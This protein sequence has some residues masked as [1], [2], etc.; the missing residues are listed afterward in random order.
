MC[1]LH[2]AYPSL[3][4]RFPLYGMSTVKRGLSKA[5]SIG[6]VITLL[7]SS[8]PAAPL[9]LRDA[10]QV[11]HAKL[12]LLSS[13]TIAALGQTTQPAG[14][15]NPS[16]A[17]QES[18]EE[19]DFRVTHIQVSPEEV[20]VHSGQPA[21]FA[22]IAFDKNGVPV[23]GVHF[24]WQLLGN[25]PEAT[26]TI[27][28]DGEFNSRQ[29]GRYRIAVRGAG[30]VAHATVN[31][32]GEPPEEPHPDRVVERREVQSRRRGPSA[33]ADRSAAARPGRKR[34]VP[35]KSSEAALAHAPG[36]LTSAMMRRFLDTAVWNDEN[37]WS[38][39]DP[40]NRRGP[41][42]NAPD[43]LGGSSSG[44]YQIVVP[45]VSLPGRGLPLD[46]K[47]VYNSRVWNKA[48]SE[49]TFDIDHDD[50]APGWS[51]GFS[52]VV[53]IGS[54]GDMIVEADGTRHPFKGMKT[55]YSGSTT[56]TNYDL[57]TTDGSFIRYQSQHILYQNGDKFFQVKAY[58]PDGSYIVYNGYKDMY[59]GNND[60]AQNAYPYQIT[61]RYGNQI[62]LRNALY[63]HHSK[64]TSITDT[65]GR[66]ILFNY[67][68]A[69]D[70]LLTSITCAGLKDAAGNTT[71]RTLLRLHYRTLNLSQY[72]SYGFDPNVLSPHVR[73]A[74]V[75]VPDAIYYPGLNTGYWF[76]E[77]D[78]YSSYG[79]IAKV[80]EHRD[81]GFSTST[82]SP[83]NE[84]GTV[85]PGRVTQRRVYDYPL[86][87]PANPLTDAPTYTKMTM[88]WANMDTGAAETNFLI[89]NNASPRR[90]KITRP[91]G[92]YSVQLSHNF[93]AL[94]DS[95]PNKLMDG[96]VY[97]QDVYDAGGTL[98][99]R[100]EWEWEMGDH[101]TPRVAREKVTD[102]RNQ[103]TKT[104]YSYG[105]YNQASEIREFGYG[106][107]PIRVTRLQYDNY[108]TEDPQPGQSW[109]Q[110]LAI[111]KLSEV[112][113]GDG[114]TRL[115][116]TEFYHEIYYNGLGPV[117]I[118]D[119]T[120]VVRYGNVSSSAFSDPLVE[121]REYDR[122]GNTTKVSVICSGDVVCEQ[123]Q[124]NFTPDVQYAYATSKIQ[125]APG[126]NTP[127]QVS[128]ST[129]FDFNT[130]L[131]LESTG[132]NSRL[133]RNTYYTDTWRLREITHPSDARTNYV[134]NDADMWIREVVST[135]PPPGGS[136]ADENVQYF[137]GLGQIRRED[138]R[139]AGNVWDIVERRYDALGRLWQQ[140]RP[141]RIGEAPL[142]DE[143]FYDA[144]GRT[145]K[146]KD[147]DGSTS[148]AF[149]NEASPYPPAAT[150]S[151]P[152]QTARVRDAW[153]RERWSRLDGLGRLAEV[154][155]PNPS[156]GG[157][158]GEAGGLLTTYTYDALNNLTQLGQGE[159]VRSFRFDALGRITRQKLP[160]LS[161]AID[162]AG[163]YVGVGG[164]GAQWSDATTYDE[165]S[166]ILTRT[167]SRGVVTSF[168]Y[169]DDANQP[170]PFNRLRRV[171]YTRPPNSV[172]APA[173]D[174]TYE[175]MTTGDR[176]RLRTV[177]AEGISTETYDYDTAGRL[178]YREL[179]LDARPNHPFVTN[180]SYDEVDRPKDLTYPSQYGVPG[181]PR[182]VAHRTYDDASRVSKL[183]VDAA[184]YASDITYDA[185][186]QIKSLAVGATGQ[187]QLT[188]TYEYDPTTNLLAGQKV[189]RGAATLLDLS[190]GYLRAGTTAGRTGQ[191]TGVV[192]NRDHR[193]DRDFEYDP[194]G[195]LKRA[196]AGGASGSWAQRY[197]Y[198][199]YGNRFVVLSRKT[200]YFV[201]NLYRITL[202]RE[203]DSGGLQAWD[204][205]MRQGYGQGQAQFLEAA[206]TTVSGFLDSPEYA[207]RQK[208]DREYVRD[209][210]RV[211]LEREPDQGGWDAWT[212]ACA[213]SGRSAIRPGFA[214]SIEF[215]NKVT[216]MYPGAPTESARTNVALAANGASATASS[217]Y[218]SGYAAGNAIN[219]D[220][221]G[222]NWGSSGGWHDGTGF[223]FPDWL[224]INFSGSKTINEIDVFS[225]QDNY[226]AP[227]EPTE[228]MTFSLYGMTGF[229]VQ[230]WDGSAWATVPGGN[231]SGNSNVWRKFAFSPV[232]TDKIRVLTKASDGWSRL[233][234]VEAYE[235]STGSIN[236]TPVPSDGW[237]YLP[238][239]GATNRINL[240][241]YEYDAAGN[242]TRSQTPYGW[243][244]YEYDAANRL[245]QVKTDLGAVLASY[246]YGSDNKRLISAEADARTYFA[247]DGSVLLAEYVETGSQAVPIWAKNYVYLEGRLLAT[248]ELAGANEAVS[249]HHPDRLGTK[250]I[251][252]AAGGS[253][254]EQATLPFGTEL[255]SEASGFTNTR[256]RFTSYDR[257]ATTGLDYA[258]NRYYDPLQGRFTQVDPLRMGAVDFQDPQTLNLYA[259]CGNDPV[260]RT[261]SRGLFPFGSIFGSIG[262]FFGGLGGL[263]FGGG[264]IIAFNGVPIY[265]FGGARPGWQLPF[266]QQNPK[267]A[268]LPTPTP[269]QS[270][271]TQPSDAGDKVQSVIIGAGKSII[272]TVPDMMNILIAANACE[273]PTPSCLRDYIDRAPRLHY[274]NGYE[275]GGAIAADVAT[276]IL[277]FS[278]VVK[279]ARA[280]R[281]ASGVRD[282]QMVRQSLNV[283]AGRTIAMASYDVQG[284]TGQLVA[285]SGEAL[286]VGTVALPDRLI[287]GTITTGNNARQAEAELKI[288]EHLARRLPFGARGRITLTIERA[289]CYSCENVIN[290]FRQLFPGVKLEVNYPK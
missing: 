207:S 111:P 99:G 39:D 226:S 1:M 277:A 278:S 19:R 142:W 166:N 66:T 119:I 255:L 4:R 223:T 68:N 256:R 62:G 182:K 224:Q 275:K 179:K 147:Y 209:L 183:D 237:G 225:V 196:S 122:Y 154:V 235:A 242:L 218:N 54:E 112:Y 120:K 79:M 201:A 141:Y 245:V 132:V 221:K 271:G 139:G 91:D 49:V 284:M 94:P 130:G 270:T 229:E 28:Q 84:Q 176:S 233:T 101:S 35:V 164:A 21:Y 194:L 267:P 53:S 260:N 173:A 93:S 274:K 204:N 37:S 250:L 148:E 168:R 70:S 219:G 36:A 165:R 195:R 216:G 202:N 191:L 234:E 31:V 42:T 287:F 153:G 83:L 251:T 241:G 96:Y 61:D 211:Y 105:P 266:L 102:S 156:G 47:L 240:P 175:Y 44:N 69:N 199:R 136:I 135:G 269:T 248:Q 100:T 151:V 236:A 283:G 59:T 10:A 41:G 186:S 177:R 43:D 64:I 162:D 137:N 247:Y 290:Q 81:M 106:A 95:D 200:E 230:Y 280:V 261:D 227:S 27:T 262:R 98:L 40:R 57:Y 185:S 76:G 87:P 117:D 129:G 38:A 86:T 149:Y 150:Q 55:V 215:A 244:R 257:S 152:G 197:L 134:Y 5:V 82:A 232:T 272:N 51:L 85:T 65:I 26:P 34:T 67:D 276:L 181:Q 25:G 60:E 249:Y 146:F 159:Q 29:P 116:R 206:K 138:A 189:I 252:S 45:I 155:E 145:I 107:T 289:P 113:E 279:G 254:S 217:E 114:T 80:E 32:S 77:P 281:L 12:I 220:R 228:T 178:N 2:P 16:R 75:Q 213:T 170:D 97:E 265:Q 208:T 128:S 17:T 172:I 192:D 285:V 63:S 88:S 24:E 72:P 273:S 210:Y 33:A 259:Y 171:S 23:G 231:V 22:A 263:L 14:Q 126:T 163:N 174:V 214:N 8:T 238:V 90:N 264:T 109:G 123:T 78:S 121:K 7:S 143:T 52:R 20:N 110:I 288:L 187:N 193:K 46:L 133:T 158:V 282:V 190:Y 286:R 115:S 124:F 144:L 118:G 92:S 188:E 167:D 198:D 131:V 140:T 73:N 56:T 9:A 50:I 6:L 203:P 30:K 74:Q 18:Q 243:Q 212:A 58:Y 15:G 253:W 184:S 125:G 13:V 205:L 268:P 180:Y 11:L 48:G 127:A 222:A 103:T 246:T 160:E 3:L 89:D 108:R 104:E 239:D 161:A 169:K 258:V 71:T 157:S